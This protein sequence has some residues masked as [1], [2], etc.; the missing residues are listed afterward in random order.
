MN[1][2]NLIYI[3]ILYNIVFANIAQ[4]IPQ[5][6]KPAVI[7]EGFKENQTTFIAFKDSANT[8]KK[9][10]M[11]SIK[12]EKIKEEN[13]YFNLQKEDYST[14]FLDTMK[15]LTEMAA[16]TSYC[17]QPTQQQEQK[18][19]FGRKKKRENSK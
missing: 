3:I 18:F 8:Y 19:I 6:I 15:I 16:K 1:F 12:E 2:I 13:F 4:E 14:F 10:Q 11:F 7:L 5:F 9:A 17:L